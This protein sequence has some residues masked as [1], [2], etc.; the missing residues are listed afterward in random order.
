VA[1]SLTDSQATGLD[2]TSTQ[3]VVFGPGAATHLQVSGIASPFPSNVTVTALDQFN[4]VA[5]GYVG[6]IHF[7]TT[8]PGAVTLPADY[9]FTTGDAGLHLFTA[10]VTLVTTGIQSVTATDTAASGITG[11]QTGIAVP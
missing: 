4:N 3:D 9:T 7:S 2:V 11:T 1:L 6:Q 5:T 8:D 10:G